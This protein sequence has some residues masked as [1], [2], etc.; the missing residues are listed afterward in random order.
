MV[1]IRKFKPSEG[2]CVEALMLLLRQ[3]PEKGNVTAHGV[4]PNCRGPE[5]REFRCQGPF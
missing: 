3:A 5:G 2:A 4:R 1:I